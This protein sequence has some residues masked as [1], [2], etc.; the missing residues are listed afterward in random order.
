MNKVLAK[1]MLLPYYSTDR[2]LQVGF[3]ITPESHRIKNSNS[4]LNNNPNY[5]HIGIELPYINKILKEMTMVCARLIHQ[6]K[7]KYQTAF[8]ATFDKQDEDNQILDETALLINLN[9]VQKLPENDID[10]IDI[11]SPV[12][13]QIQIQ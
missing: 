11:L 7:F 3:H 4:Q 1:K 10:N 8:S 13:H 9:T 12:E 5:K 2:T 6:Y